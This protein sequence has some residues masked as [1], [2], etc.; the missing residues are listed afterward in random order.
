MLVTMGFSLAAAITTALILRRAERAGARRQL[1]S[2]PEPVPGP[3]LLEAYG[4]PHVS[5]T[6]GWGA[7]NAH[8]DRVPGRQ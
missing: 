5:A 2:E 1:T 4:A 8:P 3:H 7:S 6:R